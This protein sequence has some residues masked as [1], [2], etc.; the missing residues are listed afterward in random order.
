MVPVL[1]GRH[2]RFPT[3]GFGDVES[4]GL[5]P[6]LVHGTGGTVPADWRH[7]TTDST[8]DAT[9]DATA[10]AANAADPTG[11]KRMLTVFLDQHVMIKHLLNLKKVIL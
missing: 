9:T 4:L 8:T 6:S 7:S 5:P 11:L 3:S 1:K 2:H 10:H